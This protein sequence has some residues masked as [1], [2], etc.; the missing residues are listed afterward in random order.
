MQ[1]MPPQSIKLAVSLTICMTTLK[2]ISMYMS[3]H[4]LVGS[5]VQQRYMCTHINVSRKPNRAIKTT[6]GAIQRM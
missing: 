1:S 6:K 5:P 3:A 4:I 2:A